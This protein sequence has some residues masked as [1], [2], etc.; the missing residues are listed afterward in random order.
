MGVVLGQRKAKLE[1]IMVV[2]G[3]SSGIAL[4]T[5]EGSLMDKGERRTEPGS[6]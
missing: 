2:Y 6:K 5:T 3:Y 4:D 1:M